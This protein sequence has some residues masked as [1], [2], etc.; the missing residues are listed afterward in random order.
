MGKDWDGRYET[1]EYAKSD[2]LEQDILNNI[3][4]GVVYA[5]PIEGGGTEVLEERSDGTSRLNVYMSN[6]KGGHTHDIVDS[7]GNYWRAHD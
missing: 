7:E 6:D 2:S 3:N 1:S 4:Y 5:R